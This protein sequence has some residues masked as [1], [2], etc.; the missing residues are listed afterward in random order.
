MPYIFF[1]FSSNLPVGHIKDTESLLSSGPHLVLDRVQPVVAVVPRVMTQ[2]YVLE[3]GRDRE[4]VAVELSLVKEMK[5]F[6]IRR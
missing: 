1:Y 4:G 3:V 6:D 2:Q 5:Q